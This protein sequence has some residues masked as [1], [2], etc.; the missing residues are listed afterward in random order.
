MLGRELLQVKRLSPVAIILTSL[1]ISRLCLQWVSVLHS[2]AYFDPK[3]YF[4]TSVIWDFANTATF[5]F[6]SLLAV[7]CVMVSSFT[8]PLFFWLKWRISRL[9]PWLLLSSL[10]LSYV[11]II[12]S[13]IWN[14]IQ[15]Q[16]T[17]GSSFRK[18]SVIVKLKTFKEHFVWPQQTVVLSIPFL[19]FPAFTVLLMASLSQHLEQ[20]PD[21]NTGHCNCS[22]KTH[23]M[24][25]RC[26][27]IFLSFF[28]SYFLTLFVSIL[29]S[30]LRKGPSSGAGK[31]SSTL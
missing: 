16:I 10:L 27:A 26:L 6:T 15:F 23:S 22:M 19:L 9:V 28:T 31:L 13:S 29:A 18:S 11:T 8:H 1:G 5:W 21:H 3:L 24:A 20:M 30:Y 17:M 4:S 12:P 14:H 7:F 25:L 2:F